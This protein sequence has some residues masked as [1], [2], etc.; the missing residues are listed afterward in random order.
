MRLAALGLA[1]I[2]TASAQAADYDSYGGWTG[3]RFEARN[4]FYV[5]ERKGISWLVTPKGYAF[6]SK[7]V[8]TVRYRGDFAPALG[9]SPYGKTTEAKYGSSAKWAAAVAERLREWGFNT[10]GSWADSDMMAQQ[11]PYTVN[12]NLGARA[13]ANW[14]KGTMPDFF[15]QPFRE[16]IREVCRKECQSRR[17]DPYVLGY[18]TD[19]ELAWAADWRSK[20]SLLARYLEMPEKSAGRRAA[21]GFLAKRGREVE[22][23][24]RTDEEEFLLQAAGEYFRACAEA[25]RAADP[26]HLVLG[27]R[28]AG[29]APDP[30]VRAMKGH[31]DVVSFNHYG[32]SP[33][34]QTLL[35]LYKMT[36]APVMITE[37]S[38]KA[39]DSGL[40]NTK[41]AGRALET[42]KDRADHF[43]HYVK[44]LAALPYCLG[45]HWFEHCDEPKEGRFDGENSNYGLVRINDEPWEEL[46]ERMKAV[47]P[48][49]EAI[50]AGKSR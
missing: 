45:F 3:L 44:A 5:A 15:S 34:S 23:I 4:R 40:P 30:V 1:V 49:L 47:N 42:Q 17:N 38:F 35:R 6:F 26:N 39:K 37:F 22:Q 36:G 16:T 21:Q 50:H 14:E 24:D 2:I 7:G 13:G 27:C 32:D 10:V 11:V 8:C 28:L 25:I 43:E 20:K 41:G 12:L 19:N 18:F 9:Y 31:V 29:Y 46:T 48:T 33:P